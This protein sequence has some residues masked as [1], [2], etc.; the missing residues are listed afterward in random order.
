VRAIFDE[1]LA[2]A[3]PTHA[4]ARSDQL[5]T[6]EPDPRKIIRGWGKLQA[7]VA[8]R[9]APFLLLM[10]AAA[11]TDPQLI[12]LLREIEDQRLER[13]TH[14][15]RTLLVGGHLRDG[16]TLAE[17]ADILWTCSSTELYEL[18]VVRRRWSIE[19]FTRF[20]SDAM[21]AALLPPDPERTTH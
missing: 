12:A 14:N 16:M 8:P 21:I 9:G 6:R 13:M 3:G 17:A 4:E 1:A 2:G 20:T 19:A 18:L 15:A 7:E 5:Q 11:V 10:R